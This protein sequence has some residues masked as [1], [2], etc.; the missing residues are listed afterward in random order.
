VTA[1]AYASELRATPP[2][3]A[4]SADEFMLFQRLIERHSGIYLSPS[5]QALLVGR[6]LS[7]LRALGCTSFRAYYQRVISDGSNE[8]RTRMIDALCTNE[9]HFFREP[10]H[11]AF[12]E[13]RLF[14]EW[15]R[16][17]FG[18]QRARRIRVWSAA[19]STGEEPFSLA[20]LLAHH[21][22]GASDWDCAVLAT[23]LSTRA[24]ATAQ[25]ATWPIEKSIEIP[26]PLL[27]RYMLRGTQ[28]QLGKM[29]ARRSIRQ[30]VQVEALN[31]IAAPYHVC[32]LFDVIFCRNVLI[33]FQPAQKLRV[34]RALLSHLAHGGHIIFGHAET[35]T[36]LNDELQSVAPNIYRRR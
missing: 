3:D 6:L 19:C 1:P 22:M 16:Q 10:R 36:G 28:D 26:V 11:F 18:H 30:L 12:L 32:G 7:R 9:T 31:L 8:E 4:P 27:K 5:K 20:M 33:Y 2:I 29:R 14:P 23:D 21:F 13:Q 15:R 34:I 17:A 24:L 25:Q 35:V